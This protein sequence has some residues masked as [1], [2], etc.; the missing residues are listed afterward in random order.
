MPVGL[1]RDRKGVDR[2]GG[3]ERSRNKRKEGEGKL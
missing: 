2:N 1:L 3:E